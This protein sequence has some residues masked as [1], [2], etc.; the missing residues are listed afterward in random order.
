[1]NNDQK[2]LGPYRTNAIPSKENR[3]LTLWEKLKRF[4]THR[5][6]VKCER[7]FR[8]TGNISERLWG[9]CPDCTDKTHEKIRKTERQRKYNKIKEEETMRLQAKF[10]AKQEF[11]EEKRE[12]GLSEEQI[13]QL[14][15]GALPDSE[16][17]DNDLKKVFNR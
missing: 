9:T 5:Q 12:E 8:K 10:E 4:F 16:E 7:E 1:M 14:L 3:E 6:C 13:D 2:F 11:I 17:L 15:K